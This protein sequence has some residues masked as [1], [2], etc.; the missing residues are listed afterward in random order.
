MLDVFVGMQVPE[1][2]HGDRPTQPDHP[3]RPRPSPVPGPYTPRRT[4]KVPT[5][6]DRNAVVDLSTCLDSAAYSSFFKFATD[7]VIPR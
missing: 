3:I 6:R 5:C 4:R 7:R 1:H 2:H